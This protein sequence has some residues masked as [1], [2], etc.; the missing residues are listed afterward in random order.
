MKY[1]LENLYAQMLL[2]EASEKDLTNTK[3]N[4][5]GS[6]KSDQ[7]IFGEKPDLVAGPEKAKIKEGPSYKISTS[8]ETGTT[9][10]SS[11]KSSFK[12]SPAPKNKEHDDENEEM[13]DT[14]VTPKSEVEKEEEE[15]PTKKDKYKY[16]QQESFTMS[17]FETL[18]KKTLT[19]ELDEENSE[20]AVTDETSDEVSDMEDSMED[21]SDEVE[22]TE[23]DSEDLIA[24]LRELHNKL[25]SIL[26]KLETE[27]E[28]MDDEEEAED[29]E[30]FSGEDYEDEFGG[31]D[32]GE[33]VLAKESVDKMKVLPDAKG[34]QLISKKNKVGKLHP[35]GGKSV[36]GKVKLDPSPKHFV[37][38]HKPL[39]HPTGRPEVKSSVK[40]GDFIK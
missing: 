39:Q 13:E 21:I 32:E 17:A 36:G 5:V 1:Q 34:K 8:S 22:E 27:V 33:E 7:D 28:G 9:H 38:K 37:G 16:K 15:K 30:E 18:F 10:G 31:E 3:N 26:S 19:E 14:D 11:S 12:G 6:M 4:K 23:E 35:K 40:K 29:D 20:L 24:D 25:T 2:N